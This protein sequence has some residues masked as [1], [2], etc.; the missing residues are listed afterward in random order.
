MPDGDE[1][2]EWM[3]AWVSFVH[4][5]QVPS[6][7]FADIDATT[8]RLLA[9]WVVDG[10]MIEGGFAQASRS[11]PWM[12]DDAISGLRAIGDDE[13]AALLASARDRDPSVAMGDA[14]STRAGARTLDQTLLAHTRGLARPNTERARPRRTLSEG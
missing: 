5:G 8:R 10:Q 4:A 12:I 11:V 6:A 1:L 2:G 9:V 3:S 13:G 7:R 14:W